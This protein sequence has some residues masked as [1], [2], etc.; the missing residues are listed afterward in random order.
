M[1]RKPSLPYHAVPE[2]FEFISGEVTCDVTLVLLKDVK[3]DCAVVV[4]QGRDVVVAEGKLC[5]RVDL[6]AKKT[7][8]YKVSG[9][10]NNV[11]TPSDNIGFKNV[12]DVYWRWS[13][14]D[15]DDDDDG[16]DDDDNDNNDDGNGVEDLLLLL[17]IQ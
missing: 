3:G 15:D 10:F 17:M 13:C 12:D 9:C 7:S 8:Q 4:L 11:G 1:Y 5:F 2:T 14:N 6:H 16:G